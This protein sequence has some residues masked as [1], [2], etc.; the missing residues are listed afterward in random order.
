MAYDIRLSSEYFKHHKIIKLRRRLGTD[1]IV[2][3]LQ[4]LTYV[5]E[6]R[7]DGV[8]SDMDLE[9]I[10]IAADWKGDCGELVKTLVKL[11]LLD[12]AGGIYEVHD[13]IEHNPYSVETA[14][15]GDKARFSRLKQVAPHIY[16]A[17]YKSGK[18]A[19]SKAEYEEI[20]KTMASGEK[21]Q[22]T[23]KEQAT[24]EPIE[25]VESEDVINVPAKPEKKPA[26]KITF[27][28]ATR[29][30]EGITPEDLRVWAEAYPACDID[31]QLKKM[32]AWLVS[33]PSQKKS[34]YGRFINN[35]LTRTQDSGGDRRGM[36]RQQAGTLADRHAGI[37]DFMND[38]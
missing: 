32:A 37:I 12:E 20:I 38:D 24:T 21:T 1:G 14:N 7:P 10:E 5:R 34:N 17:L 11:R 22:E 33:N 19:I 28:F 30:W 31:A 27:N 3:H 35:W 6:C 23:A 13:W 8:L 25:I 16:A 4:L 18:T 26:H 15:R 9:D 2:A 36:S 29:I